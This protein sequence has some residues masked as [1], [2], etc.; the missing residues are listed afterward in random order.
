VSWRMSSLIVNGQSIPYYDNVSDVAGSATGMEID[1][2]NGMA[3]TDMDIAG[4]ITHDDDITFI[5]PGR[6]ITHIPASLKHDFF[7]FDPT[8]KPVRKTLTSLSGPVTAR[9]YIFHSDNSPLHYQ[10]YLTYSTDAN[11]ASIATVENAFWVGEV[12]NAFVRPNNLM[13]MER[14]GDTF[15][16]SKITDFGTLMAGVALVILVAINAAIEQ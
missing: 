2:G 12:V 7:K 13:N 5:P 11:F 1:W 15:H 10:S 6:F 8:L 9:G 4:S 3:Y 16:N 14:K